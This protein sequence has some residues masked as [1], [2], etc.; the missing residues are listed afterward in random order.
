MLRRSKGNED[1][2]TRPKKER[3]G[4]IQAV[5]WYTTTAARNALYVTSRM[6]VSS[7]RNCVG[8]LASSDQ[9]TSSR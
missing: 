4:I 6:D 5:P 3:E 7:T 9:P 1:P 2:S 8:S